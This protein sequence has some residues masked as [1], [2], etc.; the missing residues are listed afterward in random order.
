MERIKHI[1]IDKY[2]ELLGIVNCR[3]DDHQDFKWFLQ[4]ME[5]MVSG[6]PISTGINGLKKAVMV[7]NY[8]KPTLCKRDN[9]L[10]GLRGMFEKVKEEE[11]N[12]ESRFRNV[13]MDQLRSTFGEIGQNESE[14][15]T[16]EGVEEAFVAVDI[17]PFQL[18]Y[19]ADVPKLLD[20]FKEEFSEFYGSYIAY[21]KFEFESVAK[22]LSRAG[23]DPTKT[24]LFTLGSAP[25]KEITKYGRH[26]HFLV[27][28]F[29]YPVRTCHPCSLID[30]TSTCGLK[31]LIKCD[32][33]LTHISRFITGNKEMVITYHKRFYDKDEAVVQAVKKRRS[34][35]SWGGPDE[36][37]HQKRS[38]KR[39]KSEH[40]NRSRKR[41]KFRNDEL[42][43]YNFNLAV[44]YATTTDSGKITKSVPARLRPKMIALSTKEQSEKTII[45]WTIKERRRY[46]GTLAYCND[47]LAE[48]KKEKLRDSGLL[49]YCT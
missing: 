20:V 26:L 41:T 1:L 12:S 13:S 49:T 33:T 46:T 4:P 44:Q 17:F 7:G 16:C 43:S 38:R 3:L 28:K 36:S 25:Y 37:E 29:K 34:R 8:P 22:A 23:Q 39:T 42:W 14:S 27:D 31:N 40:E 15:I 6:R 47:P 10:A 18:F 19:R 45:M 24:P 9:D 21:T 30:A 48:W 32:E 35:T 5:V 11:I 2:P